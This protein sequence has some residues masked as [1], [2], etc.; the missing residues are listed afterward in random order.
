M[1]NTS[2]TF[3]WYDAVKDSTDIYVHEFTEE[4]LDRIIEA[5]RRVYGTMN[6]ET[7]TLEL[8]SRNKARKEMCKDVIRLWK[9]RARQEEVVVATANVANTIPPIESTEV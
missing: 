9:D 4:N 6:A 8:A 1:A 3:T 5:G 2:I 7:M